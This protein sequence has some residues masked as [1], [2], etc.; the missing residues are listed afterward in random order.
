[1][2]SAPYFIPENRQV[3]RRSRNGQKRFVLPGFILALLFAIWL[4]YPQRQD[5]LSRFSD[6]LQSTLHFDSFDRLCFGGGE[7]R[8]LLD[9][10]LLF[11]GTG[12]DVRRVLNRAREE[13]ELKVVVLGGSVSYCRGVDPATECWPSH[14][15]RWAKDTLSFKA[16]VY[17]AAKSATPSSYYAYCLS[18]EL[19]LQFSSDEFQPHHLVSSSEPDFNALEQ[20]GPDLVVLEFGINDVYPLTD[21]AIERFERLV[22]RLKAWSSRPAIVVLE[23]ASLFRAAH[24]PWAKSPEFLHLPVATFYDVPVLSLKQLLFANPQSL[25]QHFESVDELFLLDT[26]HPSAKGHE[27]MARVLTSYLA[28]QSCHPPSPLDDV[29]EDEGRLQTKGI[30]FPLSK[31]VKSSPMPE[32]ERCILAA[33]GLSIKNNEGWEPVTFGGDKRYLSATN[34]GSMVSFE[35]NVPIGG[36]GEILIDWLRTKNFQLGDVLVYLDG[37]ERNGVKLA[38]YWSFK[39]SIGVPQTVFKNVKKGKHVITFKLL[40]KDQSSHPKKAVGFELISIIAI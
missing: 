27:L 26:N 30:F 36:E 7:E 5:H 35:L 21:T 33:A 12:N 24:T 40:G 17:N 23:T 18:S 14:V 37:D 31:T 34:P 4:L 15:D 6:A 32:D 10:S 2:A 19:S 16:T 25:L 28:S 20:D 39:A 38:S 3:D 8:E 22:R 11:G 29:D 13:E 9:R 1:M